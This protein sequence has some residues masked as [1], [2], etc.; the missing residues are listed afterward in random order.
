MSSANPGERGLRSHG[1]SRSTYLQVG[2]LIDHLKAQH[3]RLSAAYRSLENPPPPGGGDVERTDLIFPYLARREGDV[4]DYLERLSES[5]R[6]A[7]FETWL[8]Y[9]DLSAY[10]RRVDEM[11]ESPPADATAAVAQVVA[12]DRE[13]VQ[14]YERLEGSVNAPAVQRFF[15]DLRDVAEQRVQEHAEQLQQVEDL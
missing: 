14:H 8:Q 15:R 3:A 7:V 11:I 2:R 9:A 6:E 13:L 5:E 1:S 10:D 4:E 12:L